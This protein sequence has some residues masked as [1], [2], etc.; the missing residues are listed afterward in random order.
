[1]SDHII[2]EE[3]SLKIIFFAISIQI[4]ILTNKKELGK[5]KTTTFKLGSSLGELL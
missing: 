3:P 1:M 4:Y 5:A 2:Y